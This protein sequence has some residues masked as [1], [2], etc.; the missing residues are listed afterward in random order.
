MKGLED[1]KE[2]FKDQRLWI[3]VAQISKLH[4]ADDRSYLKVECIVFPEQR[5]IIATMTWESVGPGAGDFTFPTPGDLVL[6][7]FAE[8]DA[9]LAYVIRR[10]TSREDKI[11]ESAVTGDKVIKANTGKKYWNISD[12]KIF[13]S[14]S[15]TP[16]TQNLVLGQEF[17]TFMMGL[18]SELKTH[19][20]ID[21]QHTHMGNLGFFTA[22][23]KQAADFTA[24]GAK[25]DEV[26]ASPI[27]DQKILSDLSFTEK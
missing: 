14:R 9:D 24:R 21:S 13:L 26:K 17:K 19:A 4:L 18:L 27:Q 12:S 23:P 15:E 11:P 5:K 8:G 2:I 25:Y 6:I 3:G 1:L 16:P 20:T 22:P 7:A 10:L